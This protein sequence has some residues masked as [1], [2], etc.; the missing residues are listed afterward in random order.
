MHST[1]I[2]DSFMFSPLALEQNEMQTT[3]S[4]VKIG[5]SGPFLMTKT[6]TLQTSTFDI[7]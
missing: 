4:K 3:P 7:E 1:A 5:L 6:F 2:A